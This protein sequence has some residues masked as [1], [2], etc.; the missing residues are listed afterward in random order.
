MKHF[1]DFYFD[2]GGWMLATALAAYLGAFHRAWVGIVII[3][4]IAGLATFGRLA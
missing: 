4:G 3:G 1:A 2:G